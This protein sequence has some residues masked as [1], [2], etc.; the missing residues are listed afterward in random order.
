MAVDGKIQVAG[1]ASKS[2]TWK[3]ACAKLGAKPITERG[4][5]PAK[6]EGNLNDNGV[7]GVAMAEVEV[8]TETGIIAVKKT[9]AVQDVGLV[10]SLKTAESQV[11]GAVI[12]GICAALYEE[13]IFD[14]QTG[15]ALNAD[16]E[17]YKLSG[18]GD[19]EAAGDPDGDGVATRLFADEPNPFSPSCGAAPDPI[20]WSSDHTGV[21]ADVNCLF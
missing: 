21:Q 14:Q 1:D 8:D 9:V 6:D 10:I 12:M 19:I 11:Y 2:I 7:G 18:A 4:R 15:R 20:C 3:Q 13:R 16:M 17:Y 5:Q